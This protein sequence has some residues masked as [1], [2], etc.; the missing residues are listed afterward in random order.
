MKIWFLFQIVILNFKPVVFQ[1]VTS[2]QFTTA[3]VLHMKW[4][5][6]G[7]YLEV[8]SSIHPAIVHVTSILLLLLL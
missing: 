3:N 2:T 7:S 1:Q 6:S 4:L 5:Y 8:Y